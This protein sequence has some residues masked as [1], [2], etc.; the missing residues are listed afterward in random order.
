MIDLL[1]NLMK[2]E[3]E[4]FKDIFQPLSDEEAEEKGFEWEVLLRNFSREMQKMY[5]RITWKSSE[6]EVGWN[7]CRGNRIRIS[8]WWPDSDLSLMRN[9]EY[10]QL[11][12]KHARKIGREIGFKHVRVR[13]VKDIYGNPDLRMSVD[14]SECK[15]RAIEDT[16][17]G[18]VDW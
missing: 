17:Q 4:E 5:P 8:S 1:E 18:P 3:E 12:A 16:E 7:R 10:L 2:I 15:R 6:F 11:L 14:G 9:K 13:I